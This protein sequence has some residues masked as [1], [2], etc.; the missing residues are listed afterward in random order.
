MDKIAGID[1]GSR[2]V[3]IAVLKD[4]KI[5]KKELHNTVQ[6]YKKFAK[7]VNTQLLVDLDQ[8]GI[9]DTLLCSTGYGRNNINISGSICINE[10]KAHVW[11]IFFQ[12]GLKDFT[13]I[14]LGGQDVKIIKVVDSYIE[15]FVM[16]DKCAAST[17]RFFENMANVLDVEL[18][19]LFN[20]IEDPVEISSTCAIFGESEIIGKVA[21]GIPPQN[22]SSGIN[23]SIAKRIAA[24]M[25]NSFSLPIVLSGGAALN[26]GLGHFLKKILNISEILLP[27]D[28]QFNGAI[29]CAYYH[30]NRPIS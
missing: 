26:K 7:L 29:G 1:L 6:F 28:V 20:Q 25:K 9:A 22:I 2:F 10:I 8:L 24:M 5:I 30:H 27:E 15:D 19:F 16:N 18:E 12:L 3:K 23:I 11:G 17:G 14:D 4:G 21:E 13:L